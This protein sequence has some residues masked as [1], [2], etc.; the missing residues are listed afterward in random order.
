MRVF[1]SEV[2][3]GENAYLSD[4]LFVLRPFLNFLELLFEKLE[5]G[6]VRLTLFGDTLFEVFELVFEGLSFELR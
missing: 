2:F 6:L 4:D 1:S 5:L 3:H